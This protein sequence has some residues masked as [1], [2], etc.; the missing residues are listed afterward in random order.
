MLDFC[1][2]GEGVRTPKGTRKRKAEPG[3]EIERIRTED[4]QTVDKV[5]PPGLLSLFLGFSASC[6]SFKA[7]R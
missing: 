5:D 6:C 1:R 2:S 7:Y 3:S 4:R